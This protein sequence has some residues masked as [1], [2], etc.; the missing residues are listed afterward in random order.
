MHSKDWSILILLAA[1]WG[2]AFMF[3]KVATPDMGPTFLVTVRLLLAGLIF[4]PF[5][6][7]KKYRKHFRPQFRGIMILAVTNN[8]LPFAL[9]SY[10][11]LGANSNMLAIL[12]GSTA[13][14][15]MLIAYFW[16]KEKISLLQLLGILIGFL[17]I[18][19][20]VNPANASTTLISSLSCLFAA[21]CYS[22][23]S[24]YIQKYAKDANKF[25]LIGWSLLFGGLVIAPI[26]LI[27]MPDHF[28]N[29]DSVL[30]VLWLGIISTGLANLG[31]VR[32]IEKIGAVRTSTVTYLIPAFGILWGALFLN[33]VLT[34]FIFFGFILVMTG[35]YFATKNRAS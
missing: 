16:L 17:G 26:G 22:F 19:V 23:S 3:I 32:L 10:A 35:T 6:L 31:Y 8:A 33:E 18:L 29:N 9:F 4:T 1:I 13:F 2:S 11:S 25:A 34:L 5:L 21:S 24:N 27:N 12:N 30:A 15:T 20:L 28:P 7:Q 14:I